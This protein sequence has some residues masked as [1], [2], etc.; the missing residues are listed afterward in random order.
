[1]YFQKLHNDFAK[2]KLN[3]SI[4]QTLV[5]LHLKDNIFLL[6]VPCHSEKPSIP[7]QQST[8]ITW[9]VWFFCSQLFWFS[10]I[11]WLSAFKDGDI[12]LL[13]LQI[14]VLLLRST[15]DCWFVLPGWFIYIYIYI[16]IPTQLWW[17]ILTPD[18]IKVNVPCSTLA[19]TC[20]L[21]FWTRI[22]VFY[23]LR[24]TA[25]EMCWVLQDQAP[26]WA[27]LAVCCL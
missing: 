13:V 1:M 22:W 16:Y 2:E 24:L 27:C 4:R 23:V 18:K 3:S 5:G 7:S 15:W 8:T 17:S 14:P 20:T 9:R 25:E 21:K 11:Y 6:G 26:I 10:A 12:T 19:E